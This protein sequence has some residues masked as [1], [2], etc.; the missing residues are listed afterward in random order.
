VSRLRERSGRVLAVAEDLASR[1][2]GAAILF[3]CGLVVYAGRAVAWPLTAG[4]DLDEY[5]Y[6]YLQLLDGDVLLPW[7]MLFRTPGTPVVVGPLLDVAGGALAEPV[8]AL[9]YAGSIVAWSA[10]ALT[11]GRRAALATAVV[12]LAYPSYGAMFHELGS[13]LVMA[14]VFAAWALLVTRT[15]ARP[16]TVRF[17]AVGAGIAALALVRPGNVVLIAFALFPLGLPG[18]RRERLTWGAALVAAAVL[19]LAAWAV[20]NGLR[21]GEWTLARG[22]NAVI[23]FYRAFLTDRIVAADNGDAS[24]R[25]AGAIEERLL[26]REPYRSYGVTL[27]EVFSSGSARVHEDLYLLSDE[28]FGWNTDYAILRDAGIE[29]IRQQPGAYAS[30]VA[31][32]IWRELN[33][34]YYRVTGRRASNDEQE[35]VV[36]SGRRL[37]RPS[38]GQ[39]IPEGQ[40]L[41]ISRPDNRIRDV[42]S[43]PTKRGFVFLNPSDRPRFREIERRRDELIAALPDRDGNGELARR[44]N[45][46]SRWFPRPFIWLALGVVALALRRPRGAW[47]LCALAAGALLVVVLNALG[48]P[49]DLHYLLPVAPAFVLFGV[50]G[51]LGPKSPAAARS[52]NAGATGTAYSGTA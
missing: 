3:G 6:H 39:L 14:A 42:W 25:L 41:W 40:N 35:T 28:V 37:P 21:Y 30:G 51:L 24:R 49:T 45:Q 1:R 48:L 22:G 31:E 13:E 26:T 5:I 19:P 29:A 46:A 16:S 43:S 10:A 50:G 38:E 8:S 33:S 34:S 27:D 23:P 32:T 20:Q 7:S 2:L 15:A 52:T 36:V 12:L 18:T 4:R 47:T 9:L 44:L 11:F 17:A